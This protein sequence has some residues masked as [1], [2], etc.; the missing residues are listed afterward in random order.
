ML[1]KRAANSLIRVRNVLCYL[2]LILAV[3][4]EAYTVLAIALD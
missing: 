4:C 1:S 3:L 2:F